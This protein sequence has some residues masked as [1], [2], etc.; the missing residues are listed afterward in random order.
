MHAFAWA[1]L[2]DLIIPGYISSC[3]GSALAGLQ[4]RT[5]SFSGISMNYCIRDSFVQHFSGQFLI[6]YLGIKVS[7]VIDSSVEVIGEPCFFSCESLVSVT[8]ETNLQLSCLESDAFC[9][10]GLQSINHPGSLEKIHEL[11]FSPFKSLAF[12]TFEAYSRYVP[13]E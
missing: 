9:R 3:A 7:V 10:S 6:R 2:T 13:G 1:A 11:S 8:F 12:V 4:L 5:F